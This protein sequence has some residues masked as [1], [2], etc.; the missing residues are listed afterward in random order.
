M[1]SSDLRPELSSHL[2]RRLA[3]F[4]D[5]FRQN[6]ALIGPS[7]SGKTFQLQQLAAIESPVL[8]ILYCPLYR[9][10]SRSVV[11]RLASTI[12]RTG[13]SSGTSEESWESLLQRADS[14][15]PKTASALRA[16]EPLL[17]RRAYGEA[18]IR[19]LDAI[20]IL[21]EERGRPCVVI[22]DEFLLLEE[23]GLA[24]GFHELGKR[25]MTWPSVLFVLSSSSCYRARLILRERLQLLFGQ[26]ELVTL[27]ALNPTTAIPW[28]QQELRGVRGAK[29]MTPF[30]V[31][32]LGGY[33]WY[34]SVFCHRLKELDAL[35]RRPDCAE[36]LFLQTAWDLLGHSD[37]PL[38]QWCR[39]KAD[40]LARSRTGL[41]AIDALVHIAGGY[42]TAT[43]IG[44]RIGRSG[45]TE[46]LQLL[47]EQD[48]AQRN[49]S[50]WMVTDPILRGWLATVCAAEH[51]S[52]GFDGAELRVRFD[53]YLRS[54]WSAWV[55]THELSF[56]DQVIGLF[57][58]FRDETVS[59]DAKTGRLPVF[60]TITTHRAEPQEAG[61]YLIAS[62]D[63][64]RW[65]AS[66]HE[67]QVD[68]EV[69]ARFE[70]FCR[71]QTP[72][73]ARK[74]VITRSRMEPNARLVAKAANMWVWEGD[75]LTTLMGLYEPFEA[76]RGR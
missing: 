75:D 24:H 4:A 41:R 54:L 22:V 33:P 14:Q 17:T 66:V 35:G 52:T 38:H 61:A 70:T 27:E 55:H 53:R 13:C 68:E 8:L 43:E 64:K 30:L 20:P 59:L 19:S 7:G 58:K 56:V 69:V 15:I 16:I 2:T 60:R 9:E 32:W 71:A 48:L 47:V 3:A 28:V 62:G 46:G 49:G 34:L 45:L 72:K 23:V 18:L 73:P 51:G 76:N 25:V 42:R 65:C 26:F 12:L 11:L 74:V 5:G 21:S 50:C 44:K 39:S 31:Q 10:S 67:D 57:E 36:A 37:G 40:T 1:N 6:L 63:G 29:A